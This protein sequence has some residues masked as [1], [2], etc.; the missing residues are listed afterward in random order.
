MLDMSA[1][2]LHLSASRH[3]R[4]YLRRILEGCESTELALNNM[5]LQDLPVMYAGVNLW[6]SLTHLETL[7]LENNLLREIEM[8]A[9]LVLLKTL[10]LGGNQLQ[11]LP[12]S[13]GALTALTRVSLQ[14]NALTAIPHC[15]QKWVLLKDLVVADNQVVALPVPCFA[16]CLQRHVTP[17]SLRSTHLSIY[18]VADNQVAALPVP[19]FE[20]LKELVIIDIIIIIRNY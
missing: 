19:L 7:N 10:L 5:G 9:D 16:A 1:T 18:V 15:V 2:E 12:E 17:G 3:V 14:K 4:D 11:A 6:H 13:L 8:V 20:A